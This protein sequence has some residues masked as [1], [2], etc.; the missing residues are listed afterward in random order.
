MITDAHFLVALEEKER[1]VRKEEVQNNF[2]RQVA[3]DISGMGMSFHTFGCATKYFSNARK[4]IRRLRSLGFNVE[5]STIHKVNIGWFRL[6]FV[7]TL[8]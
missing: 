1:N 3:K 6:D 2:V 8:P 4:D 7:V 5:L